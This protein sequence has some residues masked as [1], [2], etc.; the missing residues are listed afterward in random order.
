MKVIANRFKVVFFNLIAPEQ[1][2]FLVGRNITDNIVI[3]QEVIHSIKSTQ[4]NKRWMAIKIDLKKAYDR[5]CWD[6]ISTSLQAAVGFSVLTK[7]SWGLGLRH[8]RDHNT[9][10][11]TKMGF[12]IVSNVNAL[13]VRVLRSKYEIPSGLPEN[14]SMGHCS[15]LWRSIAKVLEEIINKIV[16]IPTPHPSLGPD[17]IVWGA[18]STG[19]FSI[20][21]VYEKV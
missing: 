16:G 13:W 11:M 8:L 10:F 1:T 7:I 17:K 4:K 12:N 9:Y 6:F 14:L 5:V 2:G 21:S 18:T 20:K 15:F 19:S 3:A